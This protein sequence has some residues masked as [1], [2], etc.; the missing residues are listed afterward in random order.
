[1][2]L[3]CFAVGINRDFVCLSCLIWRTTDVVVR[4]VFG[5]SPHMVKVCT[6]QLLAWLG[7]ANLDTIR[8]INYNQACNGAISIVWKK[9]RADLWKVHRLRGI[10]RNFWQKT[11]LRVRLHTC[12]RLLLGRL[13]RWKIQTRLG[14]QWIEMWLCL[15]IVLTVLKVFQPNKHFTSHH[16]NKLKLRQIFYFIN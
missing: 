15:L 11:H 1:M 12:V 5:I 14:K 3:S 9:K 8:G 4:A 16:C 6:L 10:K 7:L 13:N 2:Q